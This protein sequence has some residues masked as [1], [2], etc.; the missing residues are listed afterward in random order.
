[1]VLNMLEK[2]IRNITN[3]FTEAAKNA[4]GKDLECIV[5]F[6]SYARGTATESSDIDVLVIT[7]N[8]PKNMFE[9][10]D[11]M[12]DFVLYALKKHYIRIM[13]VF[14]EPEE[15]FNGDNVLLYGILTGYD[16]LYG[17]HAW[18]TR[19]NIVKPTIKEINPE[20]LE[21]EKSWMVAELI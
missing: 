12:D 16:I 18:N 3:E 9:R 19:L 1:M 11:L 15:F 2:K 7:R 4:F 6:G 8:L 17:E 10:L 21:G 13:P 20:Y 5:L 14:Y